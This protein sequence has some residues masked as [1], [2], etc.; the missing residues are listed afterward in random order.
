MRALRFRGVPVEV[1]NYIDDTGVQVADVVVGFRQ[2]EHQDLA[3]IRAIADSTRFDFYCWDLYAR[4]ADWYEADKS[5]LQVRLDTL[6]DIEH[7]GNEVAD[8]A[9]FISDR[10]VRCH[11][12]TMARMNVQYDL[13]AWEGDILRL[14]FWARAFEILKEK[15]A[16]VSFGGME[17]ESYSTFGARRSG[18][19]K[20]VVIGP[21]GVEI[22]AEWDYAAT[23][24][25]V[26][27]VAA[28]HGFNLKV[29]LRKKAA[30]W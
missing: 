3:G 1:Q 22:D 23:R 19:T 21:G 24:R 4:V 18:K 11:L 12:L 10:I 14:H 26:E 2:I 7:G 28:R 27:D 8:I 5:H 17:S 20:Q 16:G 15:G 9:A 30:Q 6:H 29:V 25:I 13:L